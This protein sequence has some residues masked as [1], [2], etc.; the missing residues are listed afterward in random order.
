MIHKRIVLS[1]LIIAFVGIAASGTWAN[2]SVSAT[3]TGTLKAGT[4]GIKLYETTGAPFIVIG[5]VPDSTMNEI[6]FHQLVWPQ[7]GQYAVTVQD[8]KSVV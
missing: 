5:M 7:T 8:R 6:R 4:I 3:D 2:F 1:V